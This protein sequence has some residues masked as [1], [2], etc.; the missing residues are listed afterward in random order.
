[1]LDTFSILDAMIIGGAG[2]RVIHEVRVYYFGVLLV[3]YFE[4]LVQLCGLVLHLGG[5]LLLF[6]VAL[7]FEFANSETG[8]SFSDV[9]EGDGEELEGIDGK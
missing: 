6:T 5:E 1:M 3:L 8:D 7:G 2:L 4:I 9:V